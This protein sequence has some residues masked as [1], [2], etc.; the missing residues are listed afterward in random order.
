MDF[1][2]FEQHPVFSLL[3]SDERRSILLRGRVDRYF[4]GEMIF[5][6]GDYANNFA[7]ILSG[8]V[9][10][11]KV[12]RS[13]E[14]RELRILKAGDFFGEMSIFFPEHTR[15]A[16]ARAISQV[17]L[18][19]IPIPDMQELMNRHSDL[20]FLLM[21]EAMSRFRQTENAALVELMEKNR[22]L[23]QSM[24]ELKAAQEQLILKEMWEHERKMARQVQE[25]FLP[26]QVTAPEGWDLAV[27][28]KPAL[29][30][31]GDFYDIIPAGDQRTAY[32]I[33]DVTGKGMPAALVMAIT[34]SILR[35]TIQQ[36]GGAG[37]SLERMN[38]LLAEEIPEKMFVTLFLS[39]VDWRTGEIQFANAGHCLPI[40]CGANT[41]GEL[42]ARGMPL[43]MIPD[44]SYEENTFSLKRGE[45][46]LFYSD[47]LVEAHNA[48]QEMFGSERLHAAVRQM[49]GLGRA[50]GRLDGLV[51]G[52]F[53]FTQPRQEPE[54]DVTLVILGRE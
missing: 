23:A 47:G 45:W 36:G 20:A 39:F 35:V 18:L 52:F 6:E 22:Q 34:R 21:Q 12:A 1:P 3:S 38:N 50:A 28:W 10:V 29:D 25:S 2:L 16:S 11:V 31:G 14:E 46:V 32:A 40:Y 17:E 15:S 33:G 44:L 49:H 7:V 41:T 5:R 27:Y 4:P 13:Q 24:Q 42:K 51:Q 8:E 30:V 53:Q 43:G 9:K 48:E 19:K 26:Q 54:D 37:P